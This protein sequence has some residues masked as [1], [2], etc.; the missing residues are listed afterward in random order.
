MPL[1]MGGIP[2]S[3]E[4]RGIAY[5]FEKRGNSLCLC[6][7]GKFL[8]FMKIGGI[9]DAFTVVVSLLY[10]LNSETLSEPSF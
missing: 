9:P 8:M 7:H 6:K 4:N 2:S 5:G 3:F 1:K 10:L